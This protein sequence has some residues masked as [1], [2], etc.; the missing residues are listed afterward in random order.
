MKRM[1][2][3]AALGLALVI[4]G[5]SSASSLSSLTSNP[6]I[7]S[8]S[9]A[10]PGLNPSQLIGSAGSM[11]GLASKNMDKVDF[12]KLADVVPGSKDLM[13]QAAKLTGMS[14]FSNMADVS[15]AMSK[16]GLTKDQSDKVGPAMTD[17]VSKQGGA[18][19]AGKFAGALK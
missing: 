5:C 6:L 12:G 13:D 18:D 3:I 4:S 16:L 7:S 1:L 17:F 19:L 2:G 8:L 9:S 11:L 10:I 14:G 15:G